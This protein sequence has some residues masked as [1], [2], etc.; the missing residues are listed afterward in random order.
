MI[1]MRKLTANNG[2]V[3]HDLEVGADK[4]VTATSGGNEDLTKGSSLL[5]GNDLV[6]LNSSLESVDGVNL[7][8]ENASTHGVESLGATLA[9]I[10]ETGDNGDLASNHDIGGT[11]DTINEGLTATVQVV[12]LGLGDGVVDVDS[13]DKELVLLNHAVEVVDT[14][15]GL[16]GHTE[17]ALEHL[18][19]LGVDKGGEV[20]T[21]VEDEVE[22]LAILEGKELL[23]QAPVVLLLGLT[24]PGENGD[25]SSG[26]GGSGVV[27]G[28]EDVAAG[29]GNL[30]TE[31]S[32]GLDKDSGLDGWGS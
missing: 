9:D 22:L 26:N 25:T 15:G 13:G 11:L 29:P 2:V 30:S 19:V 17:A 31:G 5:H 7:S 12:E 18:G 16:F 6:T 4:D 24:L 1:G 20:T 28:G 10:T 21:V 23:L 27:L 32:E 8:D 14:S 3:A